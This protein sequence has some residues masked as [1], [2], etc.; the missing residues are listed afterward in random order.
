MLLR[1][2][3]KPVNTCRIFGLYSNCLP[4]ICPITDSWSIV[5]FP[6][7]IR[8]GTHLHIHLQRVVISLVIFVWTTFC[9]V[10]NSDIAL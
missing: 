4:V 3:L 1:A 2:Y 5:D 7:E 6:F 10:F 8:I 9:V